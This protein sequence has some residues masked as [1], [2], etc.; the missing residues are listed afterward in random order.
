[1]PGIK[2]V[3]SL[4]EVLGLPISE[5]FEAADNSGI[6]ESR[7]QM[8]FRLRDLARGLSDRDLAV[9]VAQIEAFL[10]TN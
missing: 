8:E 2:T 9:A 5:F 7:L 3:Q 4:A 10:K 6:D 1:M